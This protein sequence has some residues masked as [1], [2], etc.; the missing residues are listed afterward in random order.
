LLCTALGVHLFPV[1]PLRGQLEHQWHWPFRVSD[2]TFYNIHEWLK[3][4][5]KGAGLV[6]ERSPFYLNLGLMFPKPSVS[7]WQPGRT[8][9]KYQY[10]QNGIK[11]PSAHATAD[12]AITRTN[13]RLHL[14]ILHRQ[15][16]T[17]FDLFFHA[18][19]IPLVSFLDSWPF[20]QIPVF[21][22]ISMSVKTL[23]SRAVHTPTYYTND[24]YFIPPMLLGGGA[25][26]G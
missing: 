26:L 11:N 22:S 15:P 6:F 8:V 14:P 24:R 18:V 25:K 16:T 5:L 3:K 10:H 12:E 23:P 13:I 20:A 4:K 9:T 19:V 17:T 2:A 7:H 1:H 21:P